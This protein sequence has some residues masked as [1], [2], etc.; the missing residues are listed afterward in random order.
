MENIDEYYENNYKLLTNSEEEDQIYK[1]VGD[2]KIFRY[3]Y[4]AET[5]LRKL[6]IPENAHILDY[7]CAKGSTLKK[8]AQKKNDIVP[9][10]FD[11]TDAYRTFWDSFCP[12]ENTSVSRLPEE[13][14]GRMDIVTSFFSFEHTPDLNSIFPGLLQLLKDNGLLY[15]I[16]PDVIQNKADFIVVDHVNH[17]TDCSLMILLEKH[18]F[19]IQEIDKDSHAGAMI[20]IAQKCKTVEAGSRYYPDDSSRELILRQVK[21]MAS[22]WKN[23]GNRIRDF[24][25]TLGNTYNAVI[26]G[27]GFYGTYIMACL[28]NKDN[29]KYFID[30]DPYRQNH[31]FFNR[32][33]L[34]PDDLPVEIDAVFVGLNPAIAVQNIEII[35]S[36]KN[37][38]LNMFYL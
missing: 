37:K 3:D 9:Y 11:V 14:H 28:K 12:D 21:D 27:A 29:V 36:W 2:E 5:V 1:V 32:N 33:V 4:Q 13:W 25:K 30:R 23:I 24:E 20:V 16:V 38:N 7:G 19:R 26:Y 22:Y 6:D 34:D 10:L 18:G 31:R 15:F 8:L 35:D 17:F